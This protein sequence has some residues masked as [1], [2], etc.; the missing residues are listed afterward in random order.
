MWNTKAHFS[1]YDSH[2]LKADSS[3]SNYRSLDL[4]LNVV[5]DSSP[6]M[7]VPW[8]YFSNFD[9]S[10]C[11]VILIGV[12]IKFVYA[13]KMWNFKKLYINRLS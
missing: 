3:M 4:K 13:F 7:Q 9:P 10:G 1:A 2:G 6:S 11:L 8:P 12:V 5:Y